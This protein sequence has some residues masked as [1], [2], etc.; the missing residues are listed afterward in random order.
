MDA[1]ICVY[2]DFEERL[3]R[4]LK[5]D[6]GSIE[7]LKA[8]MANQLPAEEVLC[9]ADYVILNYEGNPRQRQV[10]YFDYILRNEKLET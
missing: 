8:R 4:L 2:L 5:R 6:G 3:R 10:G 7:A 1:V 9:R